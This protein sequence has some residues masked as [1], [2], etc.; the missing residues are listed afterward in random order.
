MAKLLFRRDLGVF[1][2]ILSAQL[3]TECISMQDIIIFGNK[4]GSFCDGWASWRRIYRN[5]YYMA[6]YG[7]DDLSEL[8]AQCADPTFAAAYTAWAA[9][10]GE[11]LARA[12]AAAAAGVAALAV[13]AAGKAV[14]FSIEHNGDWTEW[15]RI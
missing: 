5:T 13:C 10:P 15:Q 1:D 8:A 9:T 12:A 14:T 11:L 6:I 7:E 4:V 3:K 2:D